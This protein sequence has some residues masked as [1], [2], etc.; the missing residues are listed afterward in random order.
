MKKTTLLLLLN[1]GLVVHASANVVGANEPVV[2]EKGLVSGVACDDAAITV[3]KGIPFAAPPV[4]ELRWRPPQPRAPWE[5]VLKADEFCESCVQE[6]RRSFMPWTE[7]FMLR[8]DVDEDC[9]ALNIWTPAKSADEKLPVYVFI[10]GGAYFSGSGEVALY[11]GEDMAKKGIIVVTVNYRLGVFG[12]FAHPEL[13]AE[14]PQ[15]ASGNYGLMDNVA[16]LQWVKNNIA[17]FG[18]DPENVTIGGQSAGAASVHY[19]T[20]APSAKGLFQRAIAQS[21][22]WRPNSQTPDLAAGEKQGSE[23]AEAIG[24][25]S[26]ADLRALSAD[27]LYAKYQ[28]HEFRFRPI[29]DG[30]VVPD[31]VPAIH[32]AGAQNDVAMLTGYTADEGS[33]RAGYGTSTV[34]EFKKQAEERY[35]D[36][37]AD[38]LK[39][40]PAENDEQA[41]KAQI[42]SSRDAARAGIHWWTNVRAK[43]GSTPDFSYFFERAIP[44]PEHPEYGAFHSG[45]MPY[46]FDNLELMDRP[47][48][49]VDHKLADV[50]SSYWVNFIATGN[51]NGEGL[52]HWPEGNNEVMRLGQDVRSDAILDPEKLA[53]FL[54]TFSDDSMND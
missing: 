15:N 33:S 22:P 49:P 42:E 45:D 38:F 17:A 28:E 16:A 29:V 44:W 41:G 24:A 4:G 25:P 13:A 31:Q 5:G 35:G 11:D 27:E 50:A 3:F 39:L 12:F 34:E 26:L 53:F 23:F 10:H 6:L 52:P 40:Y 18:G 2:T 19:L 1:V 54:K 47:W 21:G 7:E 43:T 9:L 48:E 20:V 51:P 14:S 30:W 46:T 32:M 37:A 8:N 36:L